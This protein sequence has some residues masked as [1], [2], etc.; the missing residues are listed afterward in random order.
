MNCEFRVKFEFKVH[1]YDGADWFVNHETTNMIGYW[2]KRTK[3]SL[4]TTWD[5]DETRVF[6]E[7]LGEFYLFPV[8]T[9]CTSLDQRLFQSVYNVDPVR[10]RKNSQISS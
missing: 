2:F 5:A 1:S 6:D 4:R 10:Q 7:E 3:F 8:H 9:H